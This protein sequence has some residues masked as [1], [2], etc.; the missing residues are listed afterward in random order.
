MDKK[1]TVAE[2]LEI[3]GYPVKDRVSDFKGIAT[4]VSFDLPGCI[5]VT[6]NPGMGKD[7]KLLDS[8]WFDYHRLEKTS[9]KRCMELPQFIQDE[10]EVAQM[11]GPSEKPVQTTLK[12]RH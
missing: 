6:V 9:N 3:M 1:I 12:G 5:L 2:Y 11:K 7:G 8:V 4:A 10:T